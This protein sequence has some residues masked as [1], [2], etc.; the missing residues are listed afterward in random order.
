MNHPNETKE[1]IDIIKRVLHKN[2]NPY[3]YREDIDYGVLF[4]LANKN[5]IANTVAGVICSNDRINDSVKKQ[6]EK[7]RYQI[8]T[9]QVLGNKALEVLFTNLDDNKIR[10]IFLKGT[11]LKHLYPNPYL[12]SMSDVDVFSE[13]S[14]MEDIHSIMI[15]DGYTTGVIGFGNHYEYYL[16]N[17]V[18]VE[19]HPELVAL[20]SE[21]GRRVFTKLHPDS[22]SIAS[23]MDIWNHSLPIDNHEYARQLTPEY[24]YLYVIM[25]M[26]NHFLTAGT[27]IRSV[28]DVWIMNNHYAKMWDRSLIER[29]LTDYGLLTFEQYALALANKWFDLE[30]LQ[31]IPHDL[32]TSLLGEYEN[33]ILECGT[34]GTVKHYITGKMD[35]RTG[36]VSKARFLWGSFFLPYKQMK[37]IYRIVEKYPVVLPAMW[38]YRA[39][40]IFKKRG[41]SAKYKLNTVLNADE[42]TALKQKKLL[43][44]MIGKE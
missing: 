42:K 2:E 3:D 15:D 10:G 37:S 5:G 12:R 34:Y 22:H 35:H 9:Q 40:E 33:Y 26:M 36:V 38:C 4:M 41:K 6:F 24:H 25:H 21:Y 18:K 19:Y 1:L 39:Y 16:H 32:D 27:G 44:E 20:D 7:K 29:L 17:M 30:N 28:M 43:N 31:Y 11:V 14:D 23:Y 13:E 8:I